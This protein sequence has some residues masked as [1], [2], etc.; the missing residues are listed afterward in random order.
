MLVT[1]VLIIRPARVCHLKFGKL[2][3][4]PTSG[5]RSNRLIRHS[6]LVA[7]FFPNFF[8]HNFSL[9]LR[10]FSNHV[11]VT[12]FF[13]L[14]TSRAVISQAASSLPNCPAA[15]CHAPYISNGVHPITPWLRHTRQ[16]S[17]RLYF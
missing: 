11:E 15:C 17:L 7:F 14:A 12:S 13:H 6:H 5:T 8:S 1:P 16:G 10:R 3:Q 2:A 9:Q 4:A